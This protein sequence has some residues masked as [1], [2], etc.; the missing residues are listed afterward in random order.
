[1]KDQRVLRGPVYVLWACLFLMSVPARAGTSL[2][3]QGEEIVTGIVAV[4]A[5]LGVGIGVGVYF[6][7][8]PTIKGCVASIPGGLEI[9]N[10]KDHTNYLLTGATSG[11]QAGEV[12]SVRGR[13]KSAKGGS[14]MGTFHVNK[15]KKTLGACAVPSNP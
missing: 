6:A 1:M 3:T 12:V 5:A 15:V 9:T 7:L 10:E 13:K 14:S 8:H 11:L 2:K 4:A